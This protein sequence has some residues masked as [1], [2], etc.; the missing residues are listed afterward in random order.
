MNAATA[1]V[2]PARPVLSGQVVLDV[3]AAARAGL[4]V[5]TRF[6]PLTAGDWVVSD[7]GYVALVT[8]I[9]PAVKPSGRRDIDTT[10]GRFSRDQA[11][12]VVG[13]RA[14]PPQTTERLRP[15]V[16][17]AF[18]YAVDLKA[19]RFVRAYVALRDPWIA[20]RVT[21]DRAKHRDRTDTRKGHDA[22]VVTAHEVLNELV[23]LMGRE[24]TRQFMADSLREQFE[25][26]G[27]SF[28]WAAK[29]I[30]AIVEDDSIEPKV[31][32]EGVR[33]ALKAMA[34]PREVRHEISATV[35]AMAALNAA[36]QGGNPQLPQRKPDLMLVPAIKAT[37]EAELADDDE[38]EAMP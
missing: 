33:T 23:Q 37:V 6:E 20:A 29:Q 1:A 16:E 34:P 27:V 7:D 21:L 5:R 24:D 22:Y 26:E 14:L 13:G 3:E 19:Y 4:P 25:A 11:V 9:L 18:G 8:A 2:L 35:Q 32:L 30:R 31:R 10:A 38:K 15:Y 36:S 12:W 28:G 17:T